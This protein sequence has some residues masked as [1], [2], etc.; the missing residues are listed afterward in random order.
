[1]VIGP[2]KLIRRGK[3]NG[4]E[5]GVC[6]PLAIWSCCPYDLSYCEIC[7]Y[8]PTC[9]FE[10]L[11]TKSDTLNSN[12]DNLGSTILNF[13]NFLQTKSNRDQKSRTLI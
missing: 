4:I 8:H 9:G 7:R 10:I 13:S 5:P 2:I 6:V 11:I 1:M 12:E 3:P